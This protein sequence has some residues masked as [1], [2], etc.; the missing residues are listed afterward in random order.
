MIG[1]TSVAQAMKTRLDSIRRKAVEGQALLIEDAISA[2]FII[3][4]VAYPFYAICIHE[5]KII[6]SLSFAVVDGVTILFSRASHIIDSLSEHEISLSPLKCPEYYGLI[7]RD[8]A[9]FI[10][11][12]DGASNISAIHDFIEIFNLIKKSTLQYKNIYNER[13]SLEGRNLRSE[14]VSSASFDIYDLCRYIVNNQQIIAYPFHALPDNTLLAVNGQKQIGYSEAEHHEIELHFNSKCAQRTKDCLDTGRP[15]SGHSEDLA[16]G[17]YYIIFPLTNTW[18]LNQKTHVKNA[19]IAISTKHFDHDIID[20][21]MEY[22]SQFTSNKYFSLRTKTMLLAHNTLI[23]P[24]SFPAVSGADDF[25]AQIQSFASD[26]LNRIISTTNA[27]SATLR[28]FDPSTKSLRKVSEATDDI[29]KRDV[30]NTLHEEDSLS[31]SSWHTRVNAFTFRTGGVAFNFVY[32]PNLYTDN[33]GDDSKKRKKNSIPKAYRKAGLQD[34][35]QMRKKSKAELCIPVLCGSVPFGVINIESQIPHAFDDDIDY[36]C[37]IASS[38]GGYYTNALIKNDR[39]WLR[40]RMVE[41]DGRHELRQY[42]DLNLLPKETISILNDT[43]FKYSVDG[44]SKIECGD[45]EFLYI[46]NKHS[47]WI[48]SVYA[49]HTEERRATIK[50]ILRSHIAAN[51]IASIDTGDVILSIIKNFTHNVVRKGDIERDTAIIYYTEGADE[52]KAG[53]FCIRLIANKW[54]DRAAFEAATISPLRD[55][56]DRLHYGL[57]LIGVLTRM[58]GGSV[59]IGGNPDNGSV[60]IECRLPNKGSPICDLIRE[61][62]YNA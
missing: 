56:K 33:D 11:K 8:G 36:L 22:C 35:L 57:F 4:D 6:P 9:M 20:I 12:N 15:V 3:P 17:S 30:K 50:N 49:V 14:L 26:M 42:C 58:H 54:F 53:I 40:Q 16:A 51:T 24:D 47:E 28:V 62:S 10:Y 29:G 31:V 21:V 23:S 61:G 34:W 44:N 48:D 39:E 18:S 37:A 19:I 2:S 5:K 60:V 55:R 7:E 41:F 59:S 45:I 46:I 13:I 43:I 38:V 25:M 32:L 52:D 1:L 27:F